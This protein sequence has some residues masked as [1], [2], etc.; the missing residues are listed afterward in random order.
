MLTPSRLTGT[1]GDETAQRRL[2]LQRSDERKLMRDRYYA[3]IIISAM[4]WEG[5]S[6]VATAIH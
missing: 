3:G 6:L 2:A 1:G 4:R 5:L